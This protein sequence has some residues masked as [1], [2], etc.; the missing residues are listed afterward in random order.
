MFNSFDN[1]EIM[2]PPDISHYIEIVKNVP[3]KVHDKL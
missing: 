1:G 3:K 2:D